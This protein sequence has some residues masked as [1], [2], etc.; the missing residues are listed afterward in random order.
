MPRQRLYRDGGAPAG[1]T[2]H[3]GSR[4]GS[5]GIGS[6]WIAVYSVRG[7]SM[8]PSLHASDWL[9]VSRRALVANSPRR[10]DLV[11]VW[12]PRADERRFIKRVVGL[13][14]EEVRLSDGMLFV[15]GKRLHEP[16]LEGLPASPGLE[17]SAWALQHGQ[18]FVMGDNRAHSTDSR[19]FGPVGLGEMEGRAWFRFWPVGRW[20]R[21]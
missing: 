6:V 16:Y 7:D 4:E 15:D 3:V 13:P 11:V 5:G 9:L 17:E 12:D 10:G 8:I 2:G 19:E 1:S 14:G 20:G 21:L 18:Y